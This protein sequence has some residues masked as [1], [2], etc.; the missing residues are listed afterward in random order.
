MESL[1]LSLHVSAHCQR[2]ISWT[3]SKHCA[4][5]PETGSNK[6]VVDASVERASLLVR[7]GSKL[8]SEAQLFLRRKS[9]APSS[10]R[11]ASME[12]FE[13]SRE[14]AIEGGHGAPM[15][16]IHSSGENPGAGDGVEP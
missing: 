9:A 10:S 5:R 7:I 14:P 16:G 11:A 12:R 2:I 1:S 4:T 6:E 13:V 3:R 15:P 8:S